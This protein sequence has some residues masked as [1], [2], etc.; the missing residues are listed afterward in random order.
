MTWAD[1][2]RSHPAYVASAVG[3]ARV[4][5]FHVHCE[6]TNDL[7]V[8]LRSTTRQSVIGD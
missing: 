4:G 1:K 7:S 8:D 3:A 6:Q 2:L 5:D